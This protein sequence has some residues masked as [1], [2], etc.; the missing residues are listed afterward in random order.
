MRQA[1]GQ[2]DAEAFRAPPLLKSAPAERS[3]LRGEPTPAAPEALP[4]PAGA[5]LPA[6]PSEAKRLDPDR[7]GGVALPPEHHPWA[8]YAPG[9]WRRLRIINETF[10]DRGRLTG[11]SVSLR[12]ERLLAVGAET[13]TLLSTTHVEVEGKPLPTASQEIE[14]SLLADSPESIASAEILEPASLTVGGQMV[15]CE[16]WRITANLPR[17]RWEETVF[18][19]AGHAPYLLKRERVLLASRPTTPPDESQDQ[20]DEGENAVSPQPTVDADHPAQRSW[21]SVTRT[22]LP[23]EI[24]DKLHESFQVHGETTSDSLRVLTSETHCAAAPGGLVSART[25]E[26]DAVGRRTGW[27]SMQLV[28]L[29][30]DPEGADDLDDEDGFRPRR[31]LRLLRELE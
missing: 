28:A 18:Y 15:P 1:A 12:T 29:G 16:R 27:T 22:D 10:D 6:P 25:V 24:G 14:L 21:Q 19:A 4:A 23:A 7:L 13:Y 30:L 9:A 8:R 20:A 17:G 2:D 26:Y 5:S 31:L 3:V 11:R